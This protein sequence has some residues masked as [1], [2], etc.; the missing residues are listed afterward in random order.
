MEYSHYLL[1]SCVIAGSDSHR[2]DESDIF[3]WSNANSLR[4]FIQRK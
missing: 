1:I 3:G 4:E 2:R